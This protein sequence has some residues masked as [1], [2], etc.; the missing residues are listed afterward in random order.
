MKRK[1][2]R[3]SSGRSRSGG[4]APPSDDDVGYGKPPKKHQF[5][6]GKSGNPTGRPKGSKNTSTLFKEILDGKVTLTIAGKATKVSIRKGILT[7]IVDDA[8]KGSTKSAAF[9]L[10][11]YDA[12]AGPAEEINTW[13]DCQILENFAERLRKRGSEE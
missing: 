5:A 9:A 11:H 10:G 4:S 8:L 1:T 3:V 6:P 2:P 13:E 12:A 7:R